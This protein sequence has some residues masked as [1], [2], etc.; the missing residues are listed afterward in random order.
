MFGVLVLVGPICVWVQE[1]TTLTHTCIH[2]CFCVCISVCTYLQ[3]FFC[4][5]FCYCFC[6]HFV[7]ALVLASVIYLFCCQQLLPFGCISFHKNWTTIATPTTTLVATEKSTIIN[8]V[9]KLF[10]LTKCRNWKSNKKKNEI[11]T[12]WNNI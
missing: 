3:N 9:S 7:F 6:C 1:Y 2:L 5:N 11:K 10:A 8:F 12:Y 4:R